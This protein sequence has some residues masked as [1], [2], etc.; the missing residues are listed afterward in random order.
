MTVNPNPRSAFEKLDHL[1]ASVARQMDPSFAVT[2]GGVVTAISATHYAVSGLSKHV[3]L[4]DFVEH[5]SKAGT[6]LGQVIKVESDLVQVCAIEPGE[7][8]SIHDTVLRI[9]EFKVSPHESW[10]G[11]AI[12]ALG[13][14]IDGKGPLTQ[15]SVGR[16][17][18]NT[19]PASMSRRRVDKGFRTGV[20]AIDI[21]TPLCF[22][23][24]LGIFAGS[25]VGKSTLL[26]MLA[27][28]DA[29]DRV[30]IALVGERGREV[31]EF[32][33]DTLG[34]NMRKSIAIVATSDESPMLRKMAPLVAMTIAEH[35]RDQGEN[36]LFIADSVTRF[37]HAV[38]FRAAIR[39]LSLPSCRSCWSARGRV[40]WERA[41]SPRSSPFSWT[42]ITTTTRSRIRR[43]AF[44]MGIS[45]WSAAWRTRGATHPSTLYRR[46]PALHAKPG[47][48]TRSGSSCG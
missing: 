42:A 2:A 40:W 19:A 36:V 16:S 27:G 14:P 38:R 47:R 11:R 6:H 45:C 9:G 12:D 34:E 13:R 4:G 15:G 26:S 23:Q 3:R 31:R 37:A 32:V 17:I 48:R 35:F 1:A 33:E 25:G 29:F 28:A 5:C 20:K 22:G 39:P 24:R 18:V 43:A 7:P 46:F 8:I 21:F 10:C 41:R 44:S 30:V